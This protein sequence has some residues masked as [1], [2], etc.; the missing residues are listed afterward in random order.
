MNSIAIK[1]NYV[2]FLSPGSFLPEEQTK[3]IQT[4]NVNEAIRMSKDIVEA[5]GATPYGFQFKTMGRGDQDMNSRE[6]ARSGVYYLH[7][8]IEN[9]TEIEDRNDP[10]DRILISN[11]RGNGYKS[12]VVNKDGYRWTQPLHD[13][14]VVL[15]YTPTPTR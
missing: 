15:A 4:W 2:T 13:G 10:D 3:T 1:Q 12:V 5:Y 14:D 9:L 6:L 11:M 8:K 7:G